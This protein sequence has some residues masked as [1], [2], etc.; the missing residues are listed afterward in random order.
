MNT[1]QTQFSLKRP[2]FQINPK[3]S[4][5]DARLFFGADRNEEI[6]EKIKLGYMAGYVP[7]HYLFGDYGTGKTH[8]IYHIKHYF[9]RLHSEIAVVPLVVSMEAESKTRYQALH[10]RLLDAITIDAIEHAYVNYSLELRQDGE[11]RE[12]RF[13]ELFRSANVYNV[14]QL[15]AT[16]PANKLVAWRWLTGE[17][18]SSSEQDQIG[19]TGSLVETGD[20]VDL[21]VTI[22]DLFKRVGTNL[23]FLVDE[24]EVL[25]NVNNADAQNSWHDAFR[26]LADSN[27]NQS[28]GWILTFYTTMQDEVPRFMF[29][30]DITTRLG[31]EG[32][33][34]LEALETVQVRTFLTELLGEFVDGKQGVERAASLGLDVQEDSYPFTADAFEAFV[35]HASA[36]QHNAIPRTI[37]RALT[38]CALESLSRDSIVID[39]D[40]VDQITPAEFSG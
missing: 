27:D 28:V 15:L 24:S 5:E 7:R 13:K 19:V 16:G 37:L 34:R 40:T 26:R 36:M 14:M 32:I 31:N 8:L 21:L 20:L 17:R 39:R 2:N 38:S 4:I 10:R 22:G 33:V 6:I 11:D 30:G 12:E 35:E 25:H 23:L 3:Q 18:L 9:E 1:L 29:E